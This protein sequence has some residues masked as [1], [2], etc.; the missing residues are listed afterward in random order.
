MVKQVFVT[1]VQ[2]DAARLIVKRSEAKGK[3]V[4]SAVRKIAEAQPRHADKVAGS[5]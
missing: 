4:S 2:R 3:T 1:A 5:T